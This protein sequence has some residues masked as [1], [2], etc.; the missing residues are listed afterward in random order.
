MSFFLEKQQLPFTLSCTFG[1][2]SCH[3]LLRHL[4]GKRL[5]F[6]ASLNGEEVV[7]KCFIGAK[8]SK[9]YHREVTGLKGFQKA[10]II[11]PELLHYGKEKTLCMY[12]VVTRFI[13]VDTPFEDLWRTDLSDAQRLVWLYRVVRILGQLY[14]A[15]VTPVDI[16]LNNLLVK[17]QDIYLIDGG[18]VQV[19]H[20]GLSRKKAMANFTLFMA[21]FAPCYEHFVSKLYLVLARFTPA[22]S[23]LSMHGI[24]DQI[25][26]WRK[27]RERYLK[28]TLRTCSDFIT[29]KN[30]LRF[31]ATNRSYQSPALQ[32][33]LKNPDVYMQQGELLKQG[34]TNTV[35]VATLDDGQQVVIKKCRSTKTFSWLRMLKKSRARKAWLNAHLLAM[36][37][38]ATPQPIAML[39]RRI[40]P[41]VISSYVVSAYVPGTNLIDYFRD[42]QWSKEWNFI[43]SQVKE[44]LLSLE[45]A[46]VFH[47]DLKATN[48]IVH[49]GK[50][51]L[52]DLDSMVSCKNFKQY[53]PLW[54]K[55]SDRFMKNWRGLPDVAMLFKS[56]S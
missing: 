31:Q 6:K 35:V 46:F 14:C 19:S 55:D 17:G 3:Q 36:L 38:I 11:T 52:I 23:G 42:S 30:L 34:R 1:E 21:V 5:V 48:F 2:M 50:V 10:K 41:F 8:K 9:N 37:D 12:V 25:H 16:H 47:G 40:G 53:K 13:D 22:Y 45:K 39:E 54:Q 49:E 44:Y 29:R 20:Q 43:V 15:G 28:K 26:R 32:K 4:P 24:I 33:L 18:G 51:F 27:W 56:S 7:A